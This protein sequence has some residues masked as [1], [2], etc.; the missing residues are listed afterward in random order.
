MRAASNNFY[1][2]KRKTA[3]NQTHLSNK[4]RMGHQ[5]GISILNQAKPAGL[6]TGERGFGWGTGKADRKP[7][8]KQDYISETV[9]GTGHGT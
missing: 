5:A 4:S 2:K 9:K 6:P 3:N 8:R 7:L 1:V